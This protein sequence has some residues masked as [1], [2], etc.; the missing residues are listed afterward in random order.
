M[1]GNEI[2]CIQKRS[3]QNQ[4]RSLTKLVQR[5]FNW[6]RGTVIKINFDRI[7]K[8]NQLSH[9]WGMSQQMISGGIMRTT[10]GPKSRKL[11]KMKK[12][13]ENWWKLAQAFELL[14]VAAPQRCV[15]VFV[16]LLVQQNP[17]NFSNP[18]S[19]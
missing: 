14:L 17:S 3:I 16:I 4:N 12:T 6:V 18:A 2:L 5:H 19:S 15:L 13:G 9:N 1:N 8:F 10:A 11:W 7:F